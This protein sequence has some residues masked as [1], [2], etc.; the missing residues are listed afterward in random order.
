M[1]KLREEKMEKIRKAKVEVE[2]QNVTKEELKSNSYYCDNATFVTTFGLTNQLK[3]LI[4]DSQT[5]TDGRSKWED[6]V[7]VTCEYHLD[8]NRFLYLLSYADTVIDI[9]NLLS[10]DYLNQLM[11]DSL[12]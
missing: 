8:A 7:E 12:E 10:C 2:L 11:L 3:A 1:E 4:M 5:Y 9:T 6:W